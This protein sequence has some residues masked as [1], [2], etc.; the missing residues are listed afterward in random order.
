MNDH[1]G[2][3]HQILFIGK[4]LISCERHAGKQASKQEFQICKQRSDHDLWAAHHV[5]KQTVAT[6]KAVWAKMQPCKLWGCQKLS[7]LKILF[8]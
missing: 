4:Y 7:I 6:Q 5:S 2:L 1:P 3:S 8:I